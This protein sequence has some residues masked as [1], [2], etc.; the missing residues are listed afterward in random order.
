VIPTPFFIKAMR[1]FDH[2]SNFKGP[3]TYMANRSS[4]KNNAENDFVLVPAK[5]YIARLGIGKS[6]L[7]L[8]RKKGWLIPGRH[9]LKFGQ[10]VL[11]FWD[12]DRLREIHENCNQGREGLRRQRSTVKPPPKSSRQGV[13]WDY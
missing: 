1:D 10:V 3:E 2:Y 6:T 9:F 4:E 12:E 5:V 7:H 13:N 8:W 11:Y